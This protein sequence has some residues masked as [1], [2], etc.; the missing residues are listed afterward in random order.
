MAMKFRGW[1][2][3]GVRQAHFATICRSC[4]PLATACLLLKTE[5]LIPNLEE[6]NKKTEV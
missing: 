4:V 2:Q 3:L 5:G 1:L 6:K